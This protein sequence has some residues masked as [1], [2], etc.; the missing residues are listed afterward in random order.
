MKDNFSMHN[1]RLEHLVEEENRTQ[2]TDCGCKMEGKTCMEC[3]YIME[4][5][6]F[7]LSDFNKIE[8]IL[9]NLIRN[10]STDSNIPTES[11]IGLLNSFEELKAYVKELGAELE[12]DSKN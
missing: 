1:W 4:G 5:H 6:N 3:G 11:K 12:Q 10:T 8:T 7:Y 9:D 2:C